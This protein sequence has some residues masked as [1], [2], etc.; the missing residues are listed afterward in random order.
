MSEQ[1]SY[2]ADVSDMDGQVVMASVLGV[3][4]AEW[5]C[6]VAFC[7]LLDGQRF[8]KYLTGYPEIRRRE[9]KCQE[10]QGGDVTQS[11]GVFRREESICANGKY[12]FKSHISCKPH[13]VYSWR[14]EPTDTITVGKKP[15]L[16][17]RE[18][19]ERYLQRKRQSGQTR[20]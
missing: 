11:T 15:C 12:Q 5:V 9:S 4:R 13:F 20:L 7:Y 17:L 14:L 18:L 6:D 8:V 16:S 10:S 2:A 1:E 3:V 19:V